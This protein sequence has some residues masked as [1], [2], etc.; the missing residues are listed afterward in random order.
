MGRKRLI[1][2]ALAPWRN[3]IVGEGE[4]APDQLLANPLNWRIHPVAQQGAINELLSRVGWVQ[5]VIVNERTG[6]VIDGHAR[7]GLAISRGENAVP[8]LYVDLSEEEERLVLAALDPIGGM[9][10]ADREVLNALVETMTVE[11]SQLRALIESLIK[12][13]A[14]LVTEL[15]ESV[16]VQSQFRCPECGH[17]WDGLPR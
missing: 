11:D 17:E 15:A 10:V 9:A 8:V 3:R 1:D 12:E 5:R 6:H 16:R 2:A 13:P 4:E 14:P 7:V